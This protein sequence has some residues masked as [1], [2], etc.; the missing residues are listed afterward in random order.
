MKHAIP[1]QWLCCFGRSLT[2]KR[3]SNWYLSF[4]F[5]YETILCH[6]ADYGLS[7]FE[8][9]EMEY[10]L[11][12]YIGYIFTYCYYYA[13]GDLKGA[14]SYGAVIENAQSFEIKMRENVKI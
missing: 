8:R 1:T 7:T 10:S 12:I 3:S 13:W 6:T 14:L 4:A 2:L 11:L 5:G 9:R